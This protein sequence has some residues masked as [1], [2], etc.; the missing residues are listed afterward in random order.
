MTQTPQH[1]IAK[2]MFASDDCSGNYLPNGVYH[3]NG[4]DL[5]FKEVNYRLN[6][7]QRCNYLGGGFVS[8]E[9][10]PSMWQWIRWRMGIL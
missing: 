2:E 4:K 1:H 7:W 9:G 8:V 5:G 10:L 6:P 3:F